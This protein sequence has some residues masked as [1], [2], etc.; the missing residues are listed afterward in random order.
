MMMTTMLNDNI[1]QLW[2]SSLRDDSWSKPSKWS[3]YQAL[4]SSHFSRELSLGVL[5]CQDWSLHRRWEP[6]G[7]DKVR[8][9]IGQSQELDLDSRHPCDAKSGV[10]S[11]ANRD[12]H[13]MEALLDQHCWL[14]APVGGK[15][16]PDVSWNA[17]L[18]KGWLLKCN[19]GKGWLLKWTRSSD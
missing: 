2:W 19:P 13:A 18:A 12:T 7:L 15:L 6:G 5:K 8:S 11:W 14:S 10:R 3:F 4:Q 1:G 17:T 16:T 9:W